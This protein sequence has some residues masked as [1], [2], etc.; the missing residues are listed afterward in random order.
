MIVRHLLAVACTALLAC[1]R[2]DAAP[3]LPGASVAARADTTK[4]DTALLAALDLARITGKDDAKVWVVMVSDF[5]CPFC[6]RWHDE[7]YRALF[8]AYVATGKVRFAYVNLPLEMHANAQGAAEAAMCAG[9]SGKFWEMQDQ[10]FITQDRWKSESNPR[11]VFDSLARA[12]GVTAA[13]QARCV[14][15]GEAR[16][17]VLAD[18]DRMMRAGISSTPAFIIGGKL[19]LGAQPTEVFRKAIDAALAAPTPK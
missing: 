9:L 3:E 11:T 14:S 16:A 6:K 2:A 13:T 10:L 7:S 19:Y 12:A 4:P 8:D 1:S 5:Q 17:M 18:A 15:K